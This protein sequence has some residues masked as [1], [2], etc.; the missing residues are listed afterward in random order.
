LFLPLLAIAVIAPV[1]IVEAW[2][3]GSA[4]LVGLFA[5]IELLVVGVVVSLRSR[6]P[7]VVRGDLAA[8]LDTTSAITGE[9][10]SVLANRALSSYRAAMTDDERS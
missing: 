5:A 3:I 10:A 4:G 9:T 6:A 8:W 2:R 7:I 1:G